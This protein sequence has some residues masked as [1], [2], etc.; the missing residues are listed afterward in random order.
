MQAAA[1]D[2]ENDAALVGLADGDGHVFQPHLGRDIEQGLLPQIVGHRR[3]IARGFGEGPL[4]FGI[5]V[6]RQLHPGVAVLILVD[7]HGK[8]WL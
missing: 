7:R 1:V 6:Q 4:G 8:A 2:V 5:A 3:D